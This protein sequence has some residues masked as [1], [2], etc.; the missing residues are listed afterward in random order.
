MLKDLD[1]CAD[2]QPG[3]RLLDR[4]AAKL[5]RDSSTA[6]QKAP[7]YWASQKSG[8]LPIIATSALL[9]LA[10]WW[11]TRVALTQGEGS[12]PDKDVHL[13]PPAPSGKGECSAGA[14]LDAASA[15]KTTTDTANSGT[16]RG[17]AD[18]AA[19]RKGGGR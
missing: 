15:G 16:H 12:C 5:P 8:G 6:K 11:E 13:S 19:S 7:N 1:R 9:Q 4:L 17:S 3:V 18:R 2:N 14:T 10:G